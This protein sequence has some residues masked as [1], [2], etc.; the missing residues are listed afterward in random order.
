MVNSNMAIS[1]IELTDS[2]DGQEY[3]LTLDPNGGHISDPSRLGEGVYTTRP[4]KVK[5]KFG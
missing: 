4:Y 3:T 1:E 5:V 2:G